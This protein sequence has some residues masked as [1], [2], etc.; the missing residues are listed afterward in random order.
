MHEAAI[1]RGVLDLAESAARKREAK[2]IKKIKLQI[3]EFSGVVQEALEFAFEAL[4]PNTLAQDAELEVEI[5]KLR[6]ACENCPGIDGAVSDFNFRCPQ[7][8]HPVVIVAGREMQL[9]YLNLE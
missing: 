8:G 2:S 9:E 7:C 3:G 1:M 6:V 4:K 5:V